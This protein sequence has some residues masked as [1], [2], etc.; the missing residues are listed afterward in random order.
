MDALRRASG[1]ADGVHFNHMS[2]TL[3]IVPS[4]RPF[5]PRRI[6]MI[7]TAFTL[8][9]VSMLGFAKSLSEKPRYAGDDGGASQMDH[10]FIVGSFFFPANQQATKTIEP[11]V[12]AFD[13]PAPGFGSWMTPLGFN[14]LAAS[15]QM[16]G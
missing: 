8:L 10:G 7:L 1:V 3:C 15:A 6:R 2:P 4:G 14:F 9:G 12:R 13:D 16:Q 11:R 5:G